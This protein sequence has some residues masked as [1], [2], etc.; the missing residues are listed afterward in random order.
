M[1]HKHLLFFF[2]VKSLLWNYRI[3]QL[4]HTTRENDYDDPVCTRIKKVF[5][6]KTIKSIL[7]IRLDAHKRYAQLIKCRLATDY[8]SCFRYF[9][10]CSVTTKFIGRIL[11]AIQWYFFYNDLSIFKPVHGGGEN[12]IKVDRNKKKKKKTIIRNWLPYVI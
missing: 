10:R 4:T 11:Y 5:L 1:E 6:S 8:P 3:S 2:L 12:I 7:A 9:T